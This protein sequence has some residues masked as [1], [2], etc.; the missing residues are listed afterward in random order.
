M[1]GGHEDHGAVLLQAQLEAGTHHVDDLGVEY[2]IGAGSRLQVAHI[3]PVADVALHHAVQAAAGGQVLGELQARAL[4]R[5][6]AGDDG[7]EQA[8]VD[9]VAVFTDR[10]SPGGVGVQPQAVVGAR[11]GRHQRV[12]LE[13]ADLAVQPASI[14][15]V[16][17]AAQGAEAGEAGDIFLLEG[18]FGALQQLDGT[19]EGLLVKAGV[20]VEDTVADGLAQHATGADVGGDHRLL[21]HA[22]GDAAWLDVDG[23]HFAVLAQLEVVVGAVREHQGV[24]GTPLDARLRHRLHQGQ[25][26]QDAGVDGQRFAV[27]GPVGDVVIAEAG[28]GVDAGGEELGLLQQQAVLGDQQAGAQGVALLALLQGA[29]LVG[30]GARDHGHVAARHVDGEGALGGL[31]VQLAAFGHI[32]GRVGDGHQ[33]LPAVLQLGD[34]QGIVHVL[35][36]GAVDGEEGDLGEVAAGQLFLFDHLPLR[37]IRRLDL[38]QI[39]ACQHHPPGHVVVFLGGDELGDLGGEVAVCQGVALEGRNHPVPFLEGFLVQT[40]FGAGLDGVLDEG[41]VRHHIEAVAEHLDAADEAG[42]R[43][44]QQGIRLGHFLLFLFFGTD[45]GAHPVTVHHLLHIGRRHEIAGLL[46]DLQEAEAPIGGA[47][48]TLFLGDVFADLLF[49]LGQQR[50]VLEHKWGT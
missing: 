33:Q 6:L 1:A 49:E 18:G 46:I 41:M 30:E 12:A 31:L 38:G 44:L 9:H 39:V 43:L 45:Q 35:G 50:I 16:D 24:L 26:G 27:L 5:G 13:A 8:M 19:V 37:Q 14:Q 29:E 20:D 3:E 25:L 22:V 4:T 36:L 34:G 2:L 23:Q 47:D 21:H 7:L 17:P 42:D 15:V 11:L 10:G 32:G 40:L 48:H 28:V